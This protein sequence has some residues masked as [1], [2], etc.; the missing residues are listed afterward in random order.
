MSA[1]KAMCVD[2]AGKGVVIQGNMAFAV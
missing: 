2:E 1:V